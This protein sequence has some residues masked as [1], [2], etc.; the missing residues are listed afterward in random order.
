MYPYLGKVKPGS[1]VFVPFHTFDSNDPSASVTITGLATTDI[2]VYKDASMTQ[3]AS[4]S[5]YALVDT[6]GI[7]LDSTTGIHGVTIDL[8][9]NTTA[10]FWA[11]GS[12]YVVVVAS[13]TV[14]AATINFIPVRFS[15]GYEGAAHETSIAT[16]AS[17][18]GF[19]LTN[20]SADND[21]Y[22]GWKAI[23][24][25]V[26]SA[27]QIC[28]VYVSDYVGSTKTVTLAADP[29]IFTMAAG[30]NISLF[31]P[32]NVA[33]LVGSVTNAANLNTAASNYS[34]TRGLSGTALPAAAAD[35]AGGLP[36]S[37]AGGLDL[38]AKVGALTFTVANQLDA[39]VISVSGDSDAANNLELDY[40]G[41]GY[42]K[43]NSTIGT[44]TTNTDMR[45]TDS[46]PT[47][48]AIRSE[49]DSNSTQLAAI[50]ADTNELQGD[51]ANGGR[52]D[53]LI[54]AIKAVTD[55]IPASGAL[56]NLSAADVNAQVLDV[57]NTDTFAE[58]SS[59][60]AATTTLTNMIRWLYST[61]SNEI[62]QTATTQTL[63]NRADSA[64]IGTST[65]SDDG[66]TFVRGSYS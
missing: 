18:T 45:G 51:W 25:D 50:V 8:S 35:A 53:L 38:D 63:R 64:S 66:T 16:L 9:D 46:A 54:D 31:P 12:D 55:N 3:R 61:A 2:E 15:I 10:G 62:N 7:D 32:D 27:I 1:T 28:V 60:P 65:V 6:D 30:D 21:A 26:A 56:N 4:D 5:G 20:G 47:A 39:N 49:I 57:L 44:C 14:D 11:A 52:L 22:N 36:I 17:Q 40:D 33:A 48:A 37:D 24:H 58:L 13:I 42:N 29:G 41:T 59:V 23:V 34:A 19:T 43:S